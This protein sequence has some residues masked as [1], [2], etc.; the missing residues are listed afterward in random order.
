MSQNEYHV[1]VAVVNW[2]KVQHPGLLFTI[3]P[4]GLKLPIGLAVKQKKMGYLKGTPDLLIFAARGGHHA[5][6]VELKDTDGVLSPE[7][8][9]FMAKATE[10]GYCARVAYGFNEA[11]NIIQ[12]YVD[13]RV[14]YGKG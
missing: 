1:Q 4:G 12:D 7:Q 9:D 2:I 14:V 10:R 8:K 13:G 6:F 3:S 11:L 5:L